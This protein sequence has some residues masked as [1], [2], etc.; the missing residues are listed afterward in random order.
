M[1]RSE[2]KTEKWKIPGKWTLI[3]LL[4]L[5]A[6]YRYQNILAENYE[7]QVVSWIGQTEK[8]RTVSAFTEPDEEAYQKGCE[9]LKE[10]GYEETGKIWLEKRIRSYGIGVFVAAIG[11]LCIVGLLTELHME[12]RRKK[13]LDNQLA[14]KDRELE[15]KLAEE[16]E[17][18][19]R[20]R[21]KMG[22]YMENI[23]HQLKTSIAGT[24]LNLEVL[25]VTE[26]DEKRYQK[27]EDCVKKVQWMSDMTIVLLRLAQ[28]DSGK[29]WMKRK[30]ENLTGLIEECI[31]RTQ[32]L[33]EEK[34]VG[35]EMDVPK[36]CLLSCDG[37]WLKEAMENV[38][39][40]AVEYADTGSLIQILL[41]EDT[42][43]YKL[44]ITNRGKRIEEEKR[45]LIFDRFYQMEQGSGIGI[46]LHLAKEIVTLH[47]GT[48]KVVDRSGLE[49]ATTFQ[50]ILPKMKTVIRL[51]KVSKSYTLGEKKITA[52]KE[53]SFEVKSGEFVAVMGRSGSGKSTF[54]KIAGTLEK[55]D[56]GAVFLNGIQINGLSQKKICKIRQK[57]IGFIFQQY[58]LLPEYTIWDNVCMPLYIA[59]TVPDKAYIR[60]LL[61]KV[62]LWDRNGDYP[63]Q[64]SGGEQQRV[65][66]ARAM[67]AKPGVILADEPTGNLDYQTGQEIMKLICA[68]RE[69]YR[70]T[71][72]MVTHDMD[73]ANYAD[74]IVYMED[75]ALR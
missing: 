41:K 40:N 27:L 60:Q 43:Y 49:E 66:I 52:L 13:A 55:P 5:L 2:R 58:Q 9:A 67:A 48:L 8:D 62:G 34:G 33:A 54:L 14:E 12:K 11:I 29:I 32:P 61:E 72:V 1:M 31:D 35:F 3:F 39:K 63:D 65:A 46:G 22:T 71:I 56:T 45:E 15:A 70:Q 36:E 73:S 75:G 53:F 68:S 21:Q 18:L 30:K 7:R 20:D 64:L 6:F 17:F 74:R 51:D 42:D 16:K 50:F 57:K 28:I 37:F 26:E 19:H 47:Q 23:S 10:A 24:L 4:I 44:Y 59:H 69:L 25:L 38:L